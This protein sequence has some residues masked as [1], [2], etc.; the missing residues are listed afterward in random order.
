MKEVILDTETT[1][2]SVKEGHRIVE[3]GCIEI[4]DL[5]PTQ[6]KFHCYLNPERKVSEKALEVHGY[7]DEFLS[8][9]KKFSEIVD[10]FLNFI[11]NK[12]LVIHNAEFDLS[13]LNNELALLGRKKLKSE[14]TIDT[15]ALARDKF[16]GSP[17]SLDA[18]C[19]RYR[20]DNSKRTQH[21]ALID[22]DL[23]AKVYINLLDQKEPTLDFK[24]EDSTK[25]IVKSND[26][27]LYYKKIIKPTEEERRLHKE[28]LKNNLKK[29]FFN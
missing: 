12:R 14:N 28:Y 16:P 25:T 5:I 23:L 15:L 18:L 8:T 10:E 24:N 1:G 13:H 26:E 19:K 6:N 17:T 4:D 21:T 9:Q 7:T 22:C 3:I 20:V 27:Q 29:N 2:L 11:E